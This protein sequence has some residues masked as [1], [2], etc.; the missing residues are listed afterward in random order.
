[1]LS[2]SR[3][4]APATHT[5]R[6]YRPIEHQVPDIM[7]VDLEM[8]RMNGL[9]LTAHVR[10]NEATHGIPVIMITSRSTEKHRQQ[11]SKAGVNVYMTKPFAEDELA[12]NI[13]T[14]LGHA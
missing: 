7:L 9:E 3:F 11:A 13:G 6:F 10:T 4:I 2:R 8:P 5:V 14:C 12:S 1:M